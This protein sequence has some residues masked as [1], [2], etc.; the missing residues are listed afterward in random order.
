MSE[1]PASLSS[2]ARSLLDWLLE[3]QKDGEP[4]LLFSIT[5]DGANAAMTELLGKV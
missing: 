3:K 1:S 4:A 5:S 2:K